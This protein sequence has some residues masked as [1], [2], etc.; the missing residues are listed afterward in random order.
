MS[1][2]DWEEQ[3]SAAVTDLGL[4]PRSAPE[5]VTG[6]V[7][8]IEEMR[9]VAVQI[10][11]LRHKRIGTIQRDCEAFAL[12]VQRILPILA[13]DLTSLDAE[14]AVL[15]LEKRLEEAKRLNESKKEKDA[16]ILALTKEIGTFDTSLKEAQEI[17]F[18]LK[19]LAGAK[20][21]SELKAAISKSD[22]VS[23]LQ[24]EKGRLLQVLTEEGGG[25]PVPDL[26]TECKGVDLDQISAREESVSQDLI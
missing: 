2:A 24:K 12:E 20:E 16:S 6:Q 22:Q 8:S 13:P 17:I 11:D 1:R 25:L 23:G 14:E 26:L 4:A 7:D 3:W 10:N 18:R 21:I 9:T 15:R 19:T 5:T